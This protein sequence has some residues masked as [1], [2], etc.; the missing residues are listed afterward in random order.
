[1]I[2]LIIAAFA[3]LRLYSYYIEWKAEQAYMQTDEY[4]EMQ[5]IIDDSEEI[6]SR[7]SPAQ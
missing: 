3:A 1:M 7:Y 2:T 4:R 6:I 5:Q